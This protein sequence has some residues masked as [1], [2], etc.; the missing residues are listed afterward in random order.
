MGGRGLPGDLL[1]GR[2]FASAKFITTRFRPI[3]GVDP[4][5]LIKIVAYTCGI[6]PEHRL[7]TVHGGTSSQRLFQTLPTL[8]RGI[9]ASTRNYPKR[10]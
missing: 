7:P 6:L 5:D 8:Q 2:I 3:K 10:Y 9:S 1:I 4:K